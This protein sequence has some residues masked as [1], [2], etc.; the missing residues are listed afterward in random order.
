MGGFQFPLSDPHPSARGSN[1]MELDRFVIKASKT[2][3][4]TG[5]GYFR[6]GSPG[7][8]NF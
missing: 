7:F 5:A 6:G 1:D 4:Q 3:E 8:P 2:T